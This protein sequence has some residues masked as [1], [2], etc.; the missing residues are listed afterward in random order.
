MAIAS[1]KY[2]SLSSTLTAP[3]EID[4][5]AM[6]PLMTTTL[7]STASSVTFTS[8]PQSYEHLQIRIIG[9]STIVDTNDFMMARFNS[10]TGSNYSYHYLRG[11][12]TSG[13]SQ[14]AGFGSSDYLRNVGFITGSSATS[15]VFGV[16]IV[17]ILDYTNTNKL[18]TI[19]VFTGK[20]SNSNN[21]D[22][23]VILSS[24]LW[25]STSAINS[26]TLFTQ[27]NIATTSS[28]AL[29]GIKGAGV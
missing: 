11:D 25:N 16:S 5:G 4:L 9:R 22:G 24:M 18:K 17:D 8:I 13:T 6:I 19:K 3:A 23:R 26:I 14:G 27:S 15:N 1:L 29:Y 7:S 2:K 12:G 28:F 21:Q 20:D 10:D